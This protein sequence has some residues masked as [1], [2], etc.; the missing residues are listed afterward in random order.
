MLLI[1][2]KYKLEKTINQY[3]ERLYSSHAILI[4]DFCLA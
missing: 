2:K 4:L 1:F 3:L